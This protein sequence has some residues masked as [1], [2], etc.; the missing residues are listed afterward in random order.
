MIRQTVETVLQSRALP[1]IIVTGHDASRIRE[2]LEGLDV[3]FVHNP[4]YDEGLSTSLSAGVTGLPAKIDGVLMMLG[5]MPLVPVTTLNKL[6]AA[7]DPPG[8][9]Q[10]LSSHLPGS[11]R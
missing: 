6:I 9:A 1:V 11:A 8:G 4:R 5:D 2:A 3:S 7:F 10:H